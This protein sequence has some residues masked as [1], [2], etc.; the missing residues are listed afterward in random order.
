MTDPVWI[1]SSSVLIIAVIVLRAAF[2]KRM[3]GWLRCALWALVLIRLLVPGTFLSAPLS[4][5][6]AAQK[7]QVVRDLEAVRE[8]S[9]I[10][11]TN[12]GAVVGFVRPG[13]DA[14]QPSAT[15]AP[16]PAQ[17]PYAA[18]ATVESQAAVTH[19]PKA[20][21]AGVILESATPERFEQMKRTLEVRDVL[22][23][24]WLAGMAVSALWFAA[25][26]LRF[27]LKLRRARKRIFGE[28]PCHVYEVKDIE[29]SCCFMGSVY[30]S[31][32]TARDENELSCVM[33]HEL[34]HRRHCDGVIALLRNAALVLH[35]YNPLVWVF[36]VLARHDSELFADEGAIKALGEDERENYGRTLIALSRRC[37]SRANIACAA[38]TM[39]NGKR[40]I[41]ERIAHIAWPK[42]AGIAATALV[43]AL[44]LA[45]AGCAFSGA[46]QD[47]E[48]TS[49]DE[50]AGMTAEPTAEQG[51]GNTAEPTA[52]PSEIPVDE[53]VIFFSPGNEFAEKEGYD[54]AELW[55]EDGNTNLPEDERIPL[56]AKL[57][58]PEG[59]SVR[60][61]LYEGLGYYPDEV[62]S[63]VC[64]AA[65]FGA[66]NA[67]SIY[68]E[69]DE[70]AGT[71]G[72]VALGFSA[73]DGLQWNYDSKTPEEQ[74]DIR[75]KCCF[76]PIDGSMSSM[77][78]QSEN[79]SV[80]TTANGRTVVTRSFYS[81]LANE[82][83]TKASYTC[84]F[85]AAFDGEYDFG[86]FVEF[87]DGA[88][89]DEQLNDIAMSMRIG[90]LGS[91][92][93]YAG[94]NVTFLTAPNG[95]LYGWGA[96]DRG[97][98]GDGTN[99][100]RETPVYIG[101]GLFPI[102]VGDTVFALDVNGDLWGWGDNMYGQLGLGDRQNRNAPQRITGGVKKLSVREEGVLA[103]CSDGTLLRWG[104]GWMYMLNSIQNYTEEQE[105]AALKPQPILENVIDIRHHEAITLEHELY[106]AAGP[107]EP[108]MSAGNVFGFVGENGFYLGPN[109]ELL[110]KRGNQG[111]K[112][113]VNSFNEASGNGE[114]LYF[115]KL[116]EQTLWRYRQ[117]ISA[118]EKIMKRPERLYSD[119]EMGDSWGWDYMFG[120]MWNGEL[121]A[122]SVLGNPSVGIP[123]GEEST[124]PAKV[125][126]DVKAVYPSGCT[127]YIIK[128]DGSLW[129][130]GFG[131][132]SVMEIRSC[133]GDGTDAARW[134]FT[135]LNIENTVSVTNKQSVSV[136]DAG[137]YFVTAVS[138][139]TYAVTADGGLWAWGD[140][141]EGLLGTG[142]AEELVLL[143]T[144]INPHG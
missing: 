50:Q 71:I 57:L 119:Y 77:E 47:P 76:T 89:S 136:S 43:L 34:A 54:T 31:E 123:E 78:L 44:G 111:M 84:P 32:Q 131:S 74:L 26:N 42:K 33:Q 72:S 59:W 62:M 140:N 58:L 125:A 38:T 141:T 86:F 30:V 129:G 106:Y 45:A 90:R 56:G 135:E 39:T 5:E 100:K 138:N 70:C 19:S 96:N 16:V 101:S 41:K 22:R 35:W 122:H 52:A 81:G 110:E 113:V 118:P 93:F 87:A 25:V 14:K 27:Y 15:A 85:A 99:E 11:M 94:D 24:V 66:D 69:K 137:E 55:F 126:E 105:A 132:E 17:T 114:M 95:S 51:A 8:V 64:L 36:A 7:A 13:R 142:G 79:A 102:S 115:T 139:R 21:Y 108:L 49:P 120:L 124:I 112:P 97:Q 73:K 121:W 75:M 80:I 40:E 60:A 23:I 2:G 6:N 116:S 12:S 65:R 104:A 127:T 67:L 1:V 88:V 46:W 98:V 53:R 92:R 37:S 83:G 109:G 63:G 117:D 29:S 9:S 61:G 107:G 143:P 4:I 144:R 3:R 20:G 134:E 128:R 48:D 130:A 133:I 10:E 91:W 68:N 82:N 18:S 28:W 103:L